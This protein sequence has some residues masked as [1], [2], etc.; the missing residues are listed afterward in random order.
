MRPACIPGTA[1]DRGGGRHRVGLGDLGLGLAA[2][3]GAAGAAHSCGWRRAPR[4]CGLTTPPSRT[5]TPT[6]DHA[7]LPMPTPY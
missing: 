6:N 2:G 4:S 3:G 1:A 5:T 7:S